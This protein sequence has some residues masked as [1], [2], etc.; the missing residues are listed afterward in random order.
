MAI[1]VQLDFKSGTLAQYNQL[2]KMR[3]FKP[4]R[5]GAPGRAFPLSDESF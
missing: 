1:A 5:P 2:R 4:E 3:G